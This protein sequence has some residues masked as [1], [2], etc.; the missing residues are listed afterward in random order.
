VIV[1]G[2]GG[3]IER[4]INDYGPIYDPVKNRI[5]DLYTPD[6]FAICGCPWWSGTTWVTV[7]VY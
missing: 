1:C 6:F 2:A 5:V 7:S 4:V 3:C